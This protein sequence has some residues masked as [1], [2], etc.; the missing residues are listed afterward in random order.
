M[1]ERACFRC[2]KPGHLSRNCYSRCGSE[3]V[4]AAPTMDPPSRE[5]GPQL[6]KGDQPPKKTIE[7]YGGLKGLHDHLAE[8]G[9]E[10]EKE[11]F[12]DTCKD[13]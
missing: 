1:A 11:A 13:F 9:T 10:A 8:F 12:I 6:S 7:S 3:T 5:T 2:H 4:A